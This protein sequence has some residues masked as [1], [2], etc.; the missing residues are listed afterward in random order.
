MNLFVL[1]LVVVT[2]WFCCPCCSCCP[3][4]IVYTEQQKQHEIVSTTTKTT[5]KIKI[6]INCLIFKNSYLLHCNI[7]M[8]YLCSSQT[9]NDRMYILPDV[10]L[11]LATRCHYLGGKSDAISTRH[12]LLLVCTIDVAWVKRAFFSIPFPICNYNSCSWHY[13]HMHL[14]YMCFLLQKSLFSITFAVSDYTYG[15]LKVVPWCSN[16]LDCWWKH[17]SKLV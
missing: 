5:T 14:L 1:I 13:Y 15:S 17:M 2:M 10:V 6:Y 11:L 9:P 3:C 16:T 4:V 12:H 7:C 8:T